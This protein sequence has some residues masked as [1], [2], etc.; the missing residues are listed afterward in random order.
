MDIPAFHEVCLKDDLRPIF[1]YVSVGEK[2]V[3]TNATALAWCNADEFFDYDI[4]HGMP[5]KALIHMED[6]KKIC[7]AEAIKWKTEGKVMKLIHKNKRDELI[8]IETEAEV[9]RYPNWEAVVPEKFDGDINQIG[10]SP[11]HLMAIQKVFKVMGGKSVRMR[12][13]SSV[14]AI[15][16]T[17]VINGN[18]SLKAILM[19]VL[20]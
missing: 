4:L 19:P 7:S 12:F 1:S 17:P 16:C 18:T 6:W 2:I 11:E 15:E 3:A 5:E 10:V 8:E 20:L 13:A 9:S 14:K